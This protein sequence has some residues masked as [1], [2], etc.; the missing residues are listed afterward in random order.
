MRLDLRAISDPPFRRRLRR[1]C[2]ILVAAWL[3]SGATVSGVQAQTARISGFVTD[4]EDGKPLE[5]A[6]VALYQASYEGAPEYGTATDAGGIYQLRGIEPGRYLIQISFVGYYSHR[7]TLTFVADE[8][9][10]LTIALEPDAEALGEVVVEGER[11]F[12]GAHIA[13]GH[14]R[15]RPA[16]IALI[17]APDLSADLA[18]Y[19]SALPGIVT[20]GDR[21]GQ[22]FVRGGEPSQN[23]TLLDGIVV[24]QPFHVLGFYS[25]FPAEIIDRVDLFAGGFGARYAGRLSS[26]IDVRSRAGNNRSFGGQAGISPFLGALHLEG[27]IVP[28][29]ASFLI[30]GRQGLVERVG[31]DIY[32]QDMPFSFDDLFG[33]VQVTPSGRDRVSISV[34]RTR[35][36]GDLVH[37]IDDQRNQEIRWS[38]EGGSLQWLMLPRALP[39]A[40]QLT[41]S[42][43]RHEMEQ[44]TPGDT[45]RSTSIDET[46][47]RLDATFSEGSFFGGRSSTSAGWEAAFIRVKSNLGGIFQNLARQSRSVPAMGFYV[48]PDLRLASGLALS[49]GMRVQWYDVKIYPYFEPRVRLSWDRGIHHFTGAIGRYNQQ[50]VGV[51]DRRDAAS[52]FTAWTGVPRAGVDASDQLSDDVLRGRLG[53]A[54]HGIVG[55][56][57]SPTQRIELSIEGFYKHLDN[58]FVAEWTAIPR[59][60]TRLQPAVGRSFGA[61]ARMEVRREPIY[62]LVTYGWSNTRYSA[63]GEAIPLWY[64][65]ERLRYRPPHDRRHQ[66]GALIS[67]SVAGFELS[68]RWQFGS[69]LPYTRP[70]AFDGFALVDDIKTAFE[71]EHSRRVI[72]ERPFDSIL[73]TYHR[74]D[75]S[76]ERTWRLDHAT[77]T[78]MVGAINVYDRRNVFYVDSFTLERQD[79][80]PFMPTVGLEIG[81]E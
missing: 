58:L 27:P 42:R 55:Y 61:E 12:G 70:L 48:E 64:G 25:A 6:T 35:D 52:I 68:A 14:Q 7:D 76:A 38:N 66:L 77:V 69:G 29:K 5:G 41:L 2:H 56:R 11:A 71:L 34:L 78:L 16:E 33:K 3:L 9:R 39:L 44:G 28:G 18:G 80:L 24:Y 36:R 40:A 57:A 50:L 73:P 60:T 72:Y 4:V 17:P 65:T 20:T 22:F 10:T 47:I 19:L 26:V 45:V 54:I 13:S 43:S 1:R 51:S 79:Q 53:R 32:D 81:F 23:L 8:A 15:I 67:A 49:A 46:R 74:L 31:R 21:G 37:E 30:S 62:A 59:L 75:V 63:V